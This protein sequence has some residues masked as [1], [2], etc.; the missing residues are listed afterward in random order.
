M[1]KKYIAPAI[2]VEKLAGEELLLIES[3]GDTT[4]NAGITNGDAKE[5]EPQ[6]GAQSWG[7]LW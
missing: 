6:Q 7:N 4:S 3:A 5:R 2:T 1:N